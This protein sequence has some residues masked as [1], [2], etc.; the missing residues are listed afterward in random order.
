MMSY[1]DNNILPVLTCYDLKKF[2]FMI[3]GACK[4]SP[5]S[6]WNLVWE[7]S[8]TFGKYLTQVVI[9][10]WLSDSE[11]AAW[12][13]LGVHICTLLSQPRMYNFVHPTLSVQI[14]TTLI[15]GGK[16]GVQICTLTPVAYQEL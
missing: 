6:C 4:P 14:C 9:I 16:G 5:K 12:V 2:P 3:I 1:L 10:S 13:T 8:F 7:R 11:L 15:M